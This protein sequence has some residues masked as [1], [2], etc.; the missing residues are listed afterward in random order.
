MLDPVLRR[1]VDPPLNR[2]GA[3]LAERGTPANATTVVGLAIGLLALPLLAHEQY[4]WAL[5]VIL[6]NRLIDGLDGAIA[7]QQGPTPFGGYLDI[8]CDMAFYAAVPLGFALASPANALWAALL[9]ASFVCT[10]ASFLGRAVMAVERGE[11]D[12]GARGPKSFFYAAGIIEG[13][14]TILAFVLFCLFP[15][16]FAWLAGLFA[17]LC[18]WTATARVV[19][20]FRS[21]R[22]AGRSRDIV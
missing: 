20:A 8:V 5:L 4:D 1:W 3:W 15:A 13:T 6:L 7:R 19:A 11:A 9:L 14:E 18:F 22:G 10:A 21:E 16:A 17:A 12:D 2:A